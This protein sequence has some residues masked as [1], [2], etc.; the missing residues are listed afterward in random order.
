VETIV[1]GVDGS[2]GAGKALELAA[3]E[4]AL[5]G[6]QLRV[7]SAWQIAP[8]V[9]GGGFVAGID[10][11]VLD[12]VREDAERVVR[13]AV[14]EV[15]KLQPSVPCEGLTLEGQPAEILLEHA[16]DASLIV[17]GNRGHGGFGSL[18]L[19]SVSQQVVHHAACP[20]LVVRAAAS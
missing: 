19:G 10:A 6:A 16:R 2:A 5:R 20:V 18:L 9:Y 17:V 11:S 4:A 8:A 7:V 14:A 15:A 13:E 3:A 1:V 12:A